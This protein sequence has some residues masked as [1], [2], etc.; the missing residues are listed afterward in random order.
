M[1]CKYKFQVISDGSCDLAPELAKERDIP[2]VPFYVSLGERES[3]KEGVDIPI[4]E[5]YDLLVKNPKTFPKSACPSAQD[6][7]NAFEPYVKQQIPVICICITTKFS[8]SYQSAE[9]AKQIILEEYP[10]A[11][12]E[13]IDSTINTVLQGQYVLEAADM[14]DRGYTMEEAVRQLQ[15]IK[16]SGRILF[17]VGNLRYLQNG[18]RIGKLTGIAGTLLDIKPLITLKEG[19]IFPSGICRGRA[20]SKL[21]CHK[22][23]ADYI[24]ATGKKISELSLAVG[25]G[26]DYEE[27]ETFREESIAYLK[28]QGLEV[29]KEDLPLAQIG[30]TIA[31][32]T[33]PYPIGYGVLFRHS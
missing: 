15:E 11:R 13:V 6:F 33:G 24:K 28:D 8:A 9:I 10:Q 1:E 23:L 26:Y 12:I 21:M 22:M 5:F 20:K 31:V 3:M 7:A 2:V 25:F 19:E 17:T 30:A 29:Q 27:A 32:H 18:G 14:R 4:R 16:S